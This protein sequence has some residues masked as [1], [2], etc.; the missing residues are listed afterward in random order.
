MRISWILI[1]VPNVEISSYN[2]NIMN[3]DLSILEILEGQ[4]VLIGIDVEKRNTIN[5]SVV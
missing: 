4:L 3:I 5:V 1:T 2:K